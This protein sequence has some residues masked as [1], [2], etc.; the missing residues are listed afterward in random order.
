MFTWTNSSKQSTRTNSDMLLGYSAALGTGLPVAV[1]LRVLLSRRM[2]NAK[3]VTLLI[4]N[5]L[6]G[7]FGSAAAGVC[8]NLAMR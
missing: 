2:P 8:N 5:G 4:M 3:G 6:V 1:G 7:T